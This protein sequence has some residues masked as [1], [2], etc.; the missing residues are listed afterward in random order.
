MNIN[1]NEILENLKQANDILYENEFWQASTATTLEIIQNYDILKTLSQEVSEMDEKFNKKKQ[2]LENNSKFAQ[3]SK[4]ISKVRQAMRE[5]EITFNLQQDENISLENDIKQMRSDIKMINEEN[6]KL[7]G[8]VSELKR[9]TEA[10]SKESD[11]HLKERETIEEAEN[12]IIQKIERLKIEEKEV[13]DKLMMVTLREAELKNAEIEKASQKNNHKKRK[14][15][16]KMGKALLPLNPKNHI[17]FLPQTD[18]NDQREQ[19]DFN[20]FEKIKIGVSQKNHNG[21]VSCIAYSKANPFVASGGE[22]SVVVILRTDNSRRVAR[23]TDALK[24]IMAIAFSPNDSLFLTASYDSTI[25]I[26]KAPNFELRSNISDNKDC[27]YDAK[28][29]D[30]GKIISC[31]KD[32]T[33]KIYDINRSTPIKSFTSSSTA[34]TLSIFQSCV[35]S[36]HSDGKIRLWDYR[37]NSA[38]IEI[39]I[40]K[41]NIIQVYTE[42]NSSRIVSLGK[43]NSIQAYDFAARSILGKI[44]PLKS[45]FPSDH[46]QMAVHDD[47][48]ILGGTD[49]SIYNYSLETFKLK[50]SQKGHSSPVYC[51]AA[52]PSIGRIATGDKTGNVIFWNK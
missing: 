38:P 1:L 44:S 46:M 36:G 5:I 48:A 31:C 7:A 9:V 13:T 45:G 51:V 2:E 18:N 15:D 8:N 32:H 25:R 52:K 17:G 22:D 43:D 42:R 29:F 3:V 49:G 50:E 27:V 34:V 33:I 19:Y 40:H 41:Q 14:V 6:T 35:I 37:S 30:E 26:Y 47:Y 28:F 39:A 12:D 24:S 11:T 4:E 20:F 16:Q 23:I 10:L 21:P